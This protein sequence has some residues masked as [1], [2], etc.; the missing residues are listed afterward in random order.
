MLKYQTETLR[1]HVN[2]NDEPFKIRQFNSTVNA[3]RH[4][5]MDP[6]RLNVQDATRICVQKYILMADHYIHRTAM[7]KSLGTLR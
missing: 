1:L 2:L 4:A 7:G 3:Q 6:H 5:L